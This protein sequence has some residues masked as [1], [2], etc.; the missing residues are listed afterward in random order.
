VSLYQYSAALL[1]L[2]Q[3]PQF[4]DDGP[5]YPTPLESPLQSGIFSGLNVNSGAVGRH[6]AHAPPIAAHR[7][8]DTHNPRLLEQLHHFTHAGFAEL[9]THPDSPL[10]NYT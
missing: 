1:S 6:N 10:S 8:R 7:H 4:G 5:T 9:T 2:G 3:F